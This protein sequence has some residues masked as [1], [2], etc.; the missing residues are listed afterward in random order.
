MAPLG[1]ESWFVL[2]NAPRHD[3][4]NS[5]DWNSD[6][7][8]SGYTS[9]IINQIGAAGFDISAR[10]KWQNTI[11]PAQ[12]EQ[13]TGA[14]GGSIYGSSSNGMRAAFLRPRNVTGIENFYLV[15]GSAHPGGGLP[16]VA[17][18]ADIVAQEIGRA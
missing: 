5:V 7:L 10:I 18:S 11:S 2:V 17:M 3:P 16:L 13:R 6:E 9:S 14:H 8:V 1:D 12:L 15:G 4:A